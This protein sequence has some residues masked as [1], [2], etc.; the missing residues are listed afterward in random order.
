ME[1]LTRESG[2]AEANLEACVLLAAVYGWSC[3]GRVCAT[4]QKCEVS[5]KCSLLI[6]ERDTLLNDMCGLVNIH[7][8]AIDALSLRS[9]FP[10]LHMSAL[11]VLSYHTVLYCT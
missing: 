3:W 1:G 2:M 7:D 9:P 6:L 11:A 5:L 10:S 8:L 4:P